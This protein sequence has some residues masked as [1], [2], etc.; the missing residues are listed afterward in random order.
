MGC[1]FVGCAVPGEEGDGDVVVLEDCNGG[2]G[3]APWCRGVDC[4]DGLV[5]GERLEASAADY[6]YVDWA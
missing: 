4:C 6:G 5:A 3:I 2:G 1:E